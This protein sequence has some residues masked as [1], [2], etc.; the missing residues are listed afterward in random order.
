MTTRTDRRLEAVANRLADRR[1]VRGD[2]ITQTWLKGMTIEDLE[3]MAGIAHRRE[4]GEAE[5]VILARLD[6]ATRARVDALYA[7]YARIRDELERA[8]PAR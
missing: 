3:L 4:A 1:A 7:D 5:A 2:R 6:P 8:D